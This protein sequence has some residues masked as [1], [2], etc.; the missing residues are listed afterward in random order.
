MPI[1]DRSDS[2][3]AETLQPSSWAYCVMLFGVASAG[4]IRV[5][6]YVG[7][8]AGAVRKGKVG[9]R[10]YVFWSSLRSSRRSKRSRSKWSMV[11]ARAVMWIRRLSVCHLLRVLEDGRD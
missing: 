8:Y 6:R 11:R 2:V 1:F 7:M 10:Q 5:W 3:K 9:R 4:N